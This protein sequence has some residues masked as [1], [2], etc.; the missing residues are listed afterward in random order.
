MPL[1]ILGATLRLKEDTMHYVR[2]GRGSRILIMLPG[3]GDGLA[4]VKGTALPM[5]LM[6]RT[7]AKDFTVYM[8][9]RRNHLPEGWGTREMACD[10]KEAMDA[11]NILFRLREKAR[12]L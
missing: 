5:A 1:R 4:T 7:F 10:L 8:F 12:Q 11:L 6:Y 2:F 3:L 9:S